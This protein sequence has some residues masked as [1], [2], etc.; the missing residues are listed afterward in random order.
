MNY[1]EYIQKF[2]NF[3]IK[4]GN[5]NFLHMYTNVMP[6]RL[7]VTNEINCQPAVRTYAIAYDKVQAVA[8]TKKSIGSTGGEA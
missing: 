6:C 2:G 5:Y 8:A 4:Y 3:Q 1:N 7:K